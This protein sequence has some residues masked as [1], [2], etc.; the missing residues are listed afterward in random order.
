MEVLVE[1]LDHE[2]Y[3]DKLVYEGGICTC[4]LPQPE[5]DDEPYEEEYGPTPMDG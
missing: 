1:M 5:Y 2:D 4:E 3:C